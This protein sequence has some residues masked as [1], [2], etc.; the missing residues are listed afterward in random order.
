M[1]VLARLAPP[2]AV[3]E[4]VELGDAIHDRA[5]GAV[6]ERDAAVRAAGCLSNQV[7]LRVGNVDLAVV[8]DALRHGAALNLLAPVFE[9]T[10]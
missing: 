10:G 4:I 7:L 2:A 9:K 3:D 6:A 1:Q 5:A 8:P